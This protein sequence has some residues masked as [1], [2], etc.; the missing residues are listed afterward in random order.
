MDRAVCENRKKARATG[1]SRVALYYTQAE[2]GW[3]EEKHEE[4]SGGVGV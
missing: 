2:G 3:G 4:G 1:S